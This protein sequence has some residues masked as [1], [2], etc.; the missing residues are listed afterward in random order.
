MSPAVGNVIVLFAILILS[1]LFFLKRV[2]HSQLWQATVTPLASI[3]GSGFLISAA[4]VVLTTGKWAAVAML[5]VVTAAYLLGSV[6]RFNIQHLEPLIKK[7]SSTN[8]VLRLEALSRPMLGIAYVISVAFYLKLLSI[9][10]LQGFMIKNPTYE[11]ILTTIVL[12]FIGAFGWFRGLHILEVLEKYAVN[13][14]LIVITAM[15]I[16]HIFYNA[17]VIVEGNWFLAE[18]NH[19]TPFQAFQKLLGILIIIQGFETSRYL[20]Q[21]YSAE[22]RVKTMRYAQIISGAIYVL[23]VS[24][25]MVMFNDIH[26]VS[27]T[28]VIDL[29]RL[30]APVLPALLIFAAIM[31]QFSAAVADSIGSSG[32]ISEATQKKIS[33]KQGILITVGIS[34]LLIWLTNIYEIIVIASKAFAIYYGMQSLIAA[35]L[36][37]TQGRLLCSLGFYS[38]LVL[39][40][41]VIFLGVSVE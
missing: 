16:G 11:N 39:M 32:L 31:S 24:S 33:I 20:G 10:T 12:A 2:R 18:H 22:I 19:D 41:L 5:L 13:S 36:A 25:A 3:I 34:V 17:E 35:R 9:F 23:F 15:I 38:L 28:V 8:L 14:K 21:T 30:V 4:L 1:P 7:N 6:M 37:K 27:E 26:S 29:C 40:L